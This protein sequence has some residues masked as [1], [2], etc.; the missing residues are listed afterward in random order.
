MTR[1]AYSKERARAEGLAASILALLDQEGLLF[2]KDYIMDNPSDPLMPYF[3]ALLPRYLWDYNKD[4]IDCPNGCWSSPVSM[5]ATETTFQYLFRGKLIDLPVQHPVFT[6]RS[7][8]FAYTNYL[9]E[10]AKE[11]AI[12]AFVSRFS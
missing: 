5:K 2:I 7:C 12:N 4:T 11:A 1:K 8:G 6:C 3:S 9:A 10:D